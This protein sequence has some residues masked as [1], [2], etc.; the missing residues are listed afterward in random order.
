[1]DLDKKLQNSPSHVVN[2]PANA[3][4]RFRGIIGGSHQ[5]VK[6]DCFSGE[7]GLDAFQKSF[8]PD[9]FYDPGICKSQRMQKKYT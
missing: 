7:A 5:P 6:E 8:L 2:I 9:P 3:G 4:T 1:M